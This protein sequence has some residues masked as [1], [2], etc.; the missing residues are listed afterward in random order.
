MIVLFALLAAP[1]WAQMGDPDTDRAAVESEEAAKIGATIVRNLDDAKGLPE[2]VTTVYSLRKLDD[3][4]LLELK[5][6]K[7]LKVV[8]FGLWLSDDAWVMDSSLK[9]ISQ[10]P[11]L[12]SLTMSNQTGMSGKGI[13]F[14]AALKL[15]RVLRFVGHCTPLDAKDLQDF[16]KHPALQ[17]LEMSVNLSPDL[18]KN[19]VSIPELATLKLTI[20]TPGK[21]PLKGID[22]CKKLEVLTLSEGALPAQ[23]L[24]ELKRAKSLKSLRLE[25]RILKEWNDTAFEAIGDLKDLV[26]LEL[27][28]AYSQNSFT[29]EGLKALQNLKALTHLGIERDFS[30]AMTPELLKVL[31][32]G[33]DNLSS[34]RL[35]QMYT[36]DLA[37]VQALG[38][39]E[40]LKHLTFLCGQITDEAFKA[41]LAACTALES[42]E[43]SAVGLTAD[44][45]EEAIRAAPT[46]KTVSYY[47]TGQALASAANRIKADRPELSF[48][49]IG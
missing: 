1:T 21:D 30:K 41:V 24:T 15:L 34:L 14:L 39:P 2:D 8:H 25:D 42:L 33:F 38:V 26:R 37:V 5:K 4:V 29:A 22:K 35:E 11:A 43:I 17:E 23:A 12:E 46:L 6:R 28:P 48:K 16:R 27:A 47:E 18:I 45:F 31:L 49:R 13:S 9:L 3:T 7:S 44:G 10:F 20:R 32:A 19:L 40:K 36:L